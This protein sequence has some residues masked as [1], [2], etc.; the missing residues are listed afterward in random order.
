MSHHRGRDAEYGAVPQLRNTDSDRMAP[1]MDSRFV[2]ENDAVPSRRGR[3]DVARMRTSPEQA[4]ELRLAYARND[5]PSREQ[6]QELADRIGMYVN[7]AT[8]L[9]SRG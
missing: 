9:V 6:R 2:S 7:P 5:H 8:N 1:D 3:N 4:E